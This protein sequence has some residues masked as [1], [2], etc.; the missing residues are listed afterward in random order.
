M[1]CTNR[2]QPPG[3]S[4]YC[5]LQPER[6][7]IAPRRR[8]GACAPRSARGGRPQA[9]GDPRSAGSDSSA[10]PRTALPG[11]EP[12]GRPFPSSL[13]AGTRDPRPPPPRSRPA[14]PAPR[15]ATRPRAAALNPGRG[16]SPEPAGSCRHSARLPVAL[17][18]RR[19]A[20]HAGSVSR[21]VPVL[22]RL[23]HS[24]S[25]LPGRRS[26]G[27]RSSAHFRPA[28]A[29]LGAA[30]GGG[31]EVMR[32]GGFRQRPGRGHGGVFDSAL[33]EDP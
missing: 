7:R 10:C 22:P 9:A 25:R 18:A 31:R 15:S 12:P 4:I 17:W 21:S 2:G 32:S 29:A 13:S 20:C 24:D 33:Q 3:R 27:G 23:L 1:R 11:I 30:G 8:A 5:Y 14:L 6:T 16:L 26:G 28:G 19:A